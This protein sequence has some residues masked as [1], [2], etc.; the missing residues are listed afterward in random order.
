M[1]RILSFLRHPFKQGLIALSQMMQ[2]PSEHLF[3]MIDC[4]V[5][6]KIYEIVVIVHDVDHALNFLVFHDEHHLVMTSFFKFCQGHFVEQPIE[7]IT[8]EFFCQGKSD[9]GSH[10]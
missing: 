1:P 7:W 10:L 5:K 6:F 9:K 2:N 3:K 4:L 8:H